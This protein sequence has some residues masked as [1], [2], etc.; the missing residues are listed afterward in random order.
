MTESIVCIHGRFQPFHDEHLAY[1]LAA[2]KCAETLYIGITN[3]EGAV[4]EQAPGAP[5]RNLDESNPYPYWYRAEL[6]RGSLQGAGVELARL[7]IVPFA[8]DAPERVRSF[9]PAEALHLL[10][11]CDEWQHAKLERLRAAGFRAEFGHSVGKSITSTEV[12]R[13]LRAGEPIADIVPP[14]VEAFLREHPLPL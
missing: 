14:F 9:V 12:R 2:L 7:R 6:I 8:I 11:D 5:H 10:S 1:A 3:P 13:R 4:A